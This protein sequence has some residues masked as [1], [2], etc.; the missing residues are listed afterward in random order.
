MERLNKAIANT[1]VCSRRK[2]DELISSGRIKVNDKII[3]ELGY[4]V[5]KG[6]VIFLDDKPLHKEEYVYYLLN[7]PKNVISSTSDEKGRKTVIDIAKEQGV[8]ERLYPVGRL[9]FNTAGLIILTNDGKL[10]EKLTHPSYEVEKEYLLRIDGVLSKKE[11]QEL[12][13]KKKVTYENIDYNFVSIKPTPDKDPKFQQ[14]RIVVTE[15]KNHHVKNIFKTLGF[16]VTALT[17]IRIQDLSI[18]SIGRG[19]IR[20]LTPH[21]I[22]KLKTGN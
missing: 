21:E 10:H 18:D 8:T 6:D 3:R 5:Q 17:R 1:G 20:K 15:G 9:D 2:A 16:D 22:K 11:L 19:Y 7:K 14:L 13:K 12:N 4:K